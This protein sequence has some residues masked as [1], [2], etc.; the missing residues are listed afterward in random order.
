MPKSIAI[1]NDNFAEIIRKGYLFVDKS[2]FIKEI[3][4]D[5]SKVTLITRPRRW[6]KTLNMSMLHHFL[7]PEAYGDSTAGLFDQL[8]IA[9]APGDYVAQHQG[10]YPVIFMTLKGV[11]ASTFEEALMAMSLLIQSAFRD[12]RYLL[13]SEA[14]E[15]S[16]KEY[17][18]TV[19]DTYVMQNELE[20]SLWRLCELLYKH[21]QQ[22]TYVLIDEYDTPL[23]FAFRTDGYF[24]P[25]SQFMKNFLGHTLKSNTYLEKGVMT[26]ILRI[27]K[28]SMLS[29]L[30]N[31][32]IY[33]VLSKKYS[34]YFG[35]TNEELDI[36]FADQGLVKDEQQVKDWYNGYIIG[37]LT[38]YN[39]W[40]IMNC[41]EEKGD[42]KPYWVN[43]GNDSLLKEL[44]QNVDVDTKTAFESLI[45]NQPVTVV[46]SDTMRFDE[47][48]HDNNMLW[49]LLIFAGY[50]KVLSSELDD[51]GTRCQIAIPNQ[52]VL[53]LYRGIFLG[54]LNAPTR[55]I[56]QLKLL[57]DSLVAGDIKQFAQ[58]VQEFLQA[59]S[60]VHDYATQPEAFYHGFILALMVSMTD[61]YYVYSNTESG[62]G[63]PDL[64]LIP[65]EH[66]QTQAFVIEFKS[67]RKNE[68]PEEALNVA[69]T[70]IDNQNYAARITQHDYIKQVM[71]VAIV[72]DGREVFY[73]HKTDRSR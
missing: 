65:K 70:Q 47:V 36:L 14:L 62:N 45:V 37:G 35:F 73:N 43:T 23:N 53:R 46:V 33:T 39:P 28:D 68:K 51:M 59:A 20:R 5:V 19:C 34:P 32:K 16:D 21:H 9:Q 2:L 49:N 26:G 42:L 31:P 71:K 66:A 29:G 61:R 6:G 69:M 40:S 44:L 3:I 11:E 52:E 67:L 54:W 63:R 64:L 7:A 12:H 27:S 1:G 38:L 60:S 57:L 13:T 8:K 41:L 24:E 17:F 22:K 58:D 48:K 15:S 4:D 55:K 30:N 18:S 56:D 10:K 25:M 50:L 72:F